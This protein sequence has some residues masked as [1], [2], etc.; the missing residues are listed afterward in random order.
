[1]Y[2]NGTWLPN[3]IRGQVPDFNWGSFAFPAIDATGRGIESNNVGAQSFGINRNTRY[4]EEAFQFIVWMTTGRWDEELARQSLGIPMGL[5][6]S[7]PQQLAEAE[8]V[9]AGTTNRLPWAVGFQDD[10]D[11]NATVTANFQ[12]LVAGTM[13]AAQFADALRRL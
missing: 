11:I 13:N 1:M 4:P 3:E 8:R 7:W 2:L 9:V 12:R 5:D 6:S 10:A